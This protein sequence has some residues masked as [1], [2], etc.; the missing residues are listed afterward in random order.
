MKIRI[1]GSS[2]RRDWRSRSK[3]KTQEKLYIL[4]RGQDMKET[5]ENVVNKKKTGEGRK[6][7]RKYVN[8]YLIDLIVKSSGAR[9]PR[10]CSHQ[11]RTM[12]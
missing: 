6:E 4:H 5:E 2:W 8:K 12:Y 11:V 9:D 7:W 1:R 10:Y 3:R